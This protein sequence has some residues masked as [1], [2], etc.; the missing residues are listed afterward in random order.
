MN[1]NIL[2]R[3]FLGLDFLRPNRFK[4]IFHSNFSKPDSAKGILEKFE[5]TKIGKTIK[6]G[7]DFLFGSD[8]GFFCESVSFPFFTL[9][10][11]SNPIN[12]L[13]Q[14]IIE[15]IDYDPVEFVFRVDSNNLIFSFIQNWKEVILNPENQIGYKDDYKCDIEIFLLHMHGAEIASCTLIDSILVNANP[16]ELSLD[17]KDEISKVSISVQF[18]DVIYN[19]YKQD[20]RRTLQYF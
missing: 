14:N 12:N 5:R 9:N 19:N 8:I 10:T 2:K 17:S 20:A 7:T 16:I 1:L 11:L 6:T 15:S 3:G 18:D 4:V 13:K